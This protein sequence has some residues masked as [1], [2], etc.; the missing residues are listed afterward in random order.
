MLCTLQWCGMSLV[1]SYAMCFL[2]RG[3]VSLAQSAITYNIVK[4]K[5]T[6][7]PVWPGDL[8]EQELLNSNCEVHLHTPLR[9]RAAKGTELDSAAEQQQS[10]RR[11]CSCVAWGWHIYNIVESERE[12]DLSTFSKKNPS[13]ANW[14]STYIYPPSLAKIHQRTSEEI[15]NTQTH[16]R[17]SNYSM[18]QKGDGW[19]DG[20][21]DRWENK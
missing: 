7:W 19:M 20:W 15:G 13:R 12:S 5:V 17:C 14:R 4:V 2:Q 11:L 18:M 10:K 6:H 21:K 16:K 8:L 1:S 9:C 3:G